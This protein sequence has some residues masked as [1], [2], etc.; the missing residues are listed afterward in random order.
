[1]MRFESVD[2]THTFYRA[3]QVKAEVFFERCPV[4]SLDQAARAF[5]H[6]E[7]RTTLE[8][9]RH[10]VS[11]GRLVSVARGVYARVPRGVEPGDFLPDGFLVAVAV[12]EDAVFSHHSALDLLGAAHSVWNVITVVTTRPR[13]ALQLEKQRI[14]FLAPPAPLVRAR[15][16]SL[17]LRTVDRLGQSLRATGPERTLVAGFRDLGY[18]GGPSELVDSA[19]SFGVLDLELL[20]RLLDIYSEK[21][22][23]AAVG[24]FLERHQRSFSVP[25][26]YLGQLERRRPRSPHYLLRG[27]RGGTLARRWNLILPEDLTSQEPD[28]R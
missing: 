1:M 21:G 3:C 18:V 19:A 26:G 11:S 20:R 23:Y 13:K 9:L 27:R 15:Q 5:G 25:E 28:E 2:N 8:R 14:V 4:F 10:H 12:R 7:H 24:W 22:L 17:G 16:Q 6:E